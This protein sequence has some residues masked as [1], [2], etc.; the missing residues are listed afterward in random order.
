MDCRDIDS[1]TFKYYTF[2]FLHILKKNGIYCRKYCP[3]VK[4]TLKTCNILDDYTGKITPRRVGKPET[5]LGLF[6]E[7]AKELSRLLAAHPKMEYDMKLYFNIDN[8]KTFKEILNDWK[9][10]FSILGI[11]FIGGNFNLP[12]KD[13]SKV[14]ESYYNKIGT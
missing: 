9:L 1:K 14:I 10:F 6:S 13:A 12:T 3:T 11:R 7:D 8:K 2:Q 5:I 4:S